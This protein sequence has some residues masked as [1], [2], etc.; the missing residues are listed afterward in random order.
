MNSYEQLLFRHCQESDELIVLTAENRGHLRNVPPLLGNRFIDVGIAEQTMI[1]M[2]AGMAVRGRTVVTHALAAFLTM[3]AFEFIRDDV[4]IPNAS[5]LMVGMVPGLL[6]DGNGPTHQA[7]EDVAIMR[8][9][10]NIG[11]F[12]PMDIDE[13]VEGMDYL[14]TDGKPYY[15]RYIGLPPV[16]AHTEPFLPGVAEVLHGNDISSPDVTILSYGFMCRIALSI[17]PL[18]ESKNIRVRLVN[19]RTL[20]PIDEW[21]IRHELEDAQVVVTLEDHLLTG[22]LYSIVGEVLLRNHIPEHASV[23]PIALSSWFKP[24]RLQ[25]VLA[26]EGLDPVALASRIETFF[27]THIKESVVHE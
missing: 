11:V 3:R 10:P 4:G 14:I 21:R 5:V 15:V 27:S 23:F 17:I 13:F 25:E 22:G 6:S 18:L 16:A 19:M 8:G 20:K 7:I 1:G 9:I 26:Y 2:A 24:G 12:C